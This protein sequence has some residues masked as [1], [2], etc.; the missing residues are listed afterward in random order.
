M[1]PC[2]RRPWRRSSTLPASG[3]PPPSRR[4]GQGKR[5]TPAPNRMPTVLTLHGSS[6]IIFCGSGRS[7]DVCR[8][9]VPYSLALLFHRAL[10]RSA[11][12]T[13]RSTDRMRYRSR[14]Y[15][16]SRSPLPPAS[17]MSRA[18]SPLIVS[19]LFSGEDNLLLAE[20]GRDLHV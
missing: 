9:G 1:S 15:D 10:P 5:F 3:S 6:F 16:G 17:S 11:L 19:S 7:D 13:Q 2:P 8:S 14:C 12:L 18:V 4:A 20:S